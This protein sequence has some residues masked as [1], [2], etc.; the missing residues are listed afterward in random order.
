MVNPVPNTSTLQKRIFFNDVPIILEVTQAITHGVSIFA[1]DKW[2]SHFWVLCITFNVERRRVHRTINVC[3]PFQACAFVLNRTRTIECF[4]CVVSNIE[5]YTI[6]SFVTQRPNNDTRVILV[7][8]VHVCCTV[9]VRLHKQWVVTQCTAYTQVVSLTM[10]FNV[11]FIN[12]ID[13][14]FVAKFVETFLLWIVAC[15]NSVHVVLLP[16]FKILT[17]Q[18][19]VNVVTSLFVVLVIVYTLHQD[20]LTVHGELVVNHRYCAETNFTADGFDNIAILLFQAYHQC[21]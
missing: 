2:A 4:Q 6:T 18:R 12:Y 16:Q 8:F 15:A 20:R 10:A 1:K 5:V 14:I 19:F 11:G 3:I 7:A 21:I 17:Q 13:T 9:D